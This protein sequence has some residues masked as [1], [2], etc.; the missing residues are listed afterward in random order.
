MKNLIASLALAAAATGM[1]SGCYAPFGQSGG[2]AYA[3]ARYAGASANQ[4]ATTASEFEQLSA[5]YFA[6][7]EPK[8]YSDNEAAFAR[9]EAQLRA[10]GAFDAV[11]SARLR[12][13]YSK[14]DFSL[15][16]Q[17]AEERARHAL[18]KDK[19]LDGTRTID[20]L[21]WSDRLE[22]E[23]YAALAASN[24]ARTA[25]V[26]A[27]LGETTAEVAAKRQAVKAL[28]QRRAELELR[29]QEAAFEEALAEAGASE[30]PEAFPPAE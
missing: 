1:G 29:E 30:E 15:R 6:L 13:E 28:E 2:A 8:A 25:D 11:Q 24:Q 23:E 10:I 26:L 4:L 27:F 18:L 20:N 7:A 12:Q 19:I 14:A 17:V 9:A 21:M 3:K 22:A 16:R 5:K